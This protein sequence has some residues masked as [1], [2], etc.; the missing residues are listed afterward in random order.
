VIV[1]ESEAGAD[2]GLA[3]TSGIEGDAEARGDVVV[4]TGMPSTTPRACSAAAL[5]AVAGVKSGLISTS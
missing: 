1:E 3:V 4:I 2:D 5:I